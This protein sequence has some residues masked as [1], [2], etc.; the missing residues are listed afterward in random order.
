MSQRHCPQ[1]TTFLNGRG[2]TIFETEGGKRET[3]IIPSA[4]VLGVT[5]TTGMTPALR[6]ADSDES[7]F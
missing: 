5:D 3:I 1:T 2:T 4:T 6:L 7:H